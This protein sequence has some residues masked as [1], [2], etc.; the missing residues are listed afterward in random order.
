MKYSDAPSKQAGMV[1]ILVTIVFLLAALWLQS[2]SLEKTIVS[3]KKHLE[4]LE[5]QIKEEE[6]REKEIEELRQFMKTDEF[7]EQAAREK[8]GYVKENEIVFEEEP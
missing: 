8:L 2:R 3:Q 6:D 5:A 1:V 7:A 4:E